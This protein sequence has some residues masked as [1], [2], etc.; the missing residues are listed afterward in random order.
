MTHRT[1]RTIGSPSI[2]PLP[3]DAGL[4]GRTIH[5]INSLPLDT[6]YDIRAVTADGI[7]TGDITIVQGMAD[8][9]DPSA[10]YSYPVNPGDEYVVPVVVGMG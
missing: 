3:E 8:S 2:P 7:S 6:S 1:P 5:F 4:V 10:G 9:T